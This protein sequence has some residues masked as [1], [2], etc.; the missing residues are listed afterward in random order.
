MKARMLSALVLVLLATSL[1]GSLSI[2][3]T[4]PL[5][6]FDCTGDLFVLDDG[7]ECIL[8]ITPG[9]V[10]AIEV[11]EAQILAAT[12]ETEVDFIDNGIAFDA[13]GAM[14]FTENASNAILKRVPGG[15]VTVLTTEADIAAATGAQESDEGEQDGVD[16]EGIAFSDDGFLYVSDDWSDFVLQVDPTTGAVTAYVT[17]A[18]L[19]ALGVIANADLESSIVGAEGGIVYTASDGDPDAIFKI[20][21]GGTPSVLASGAPFA[22]LDVFMTR[23]PNG[24]LIIADDD[25]DTIRRVTPAGVVST[26]LSEA[27]LEDATCVGQEVNLQGGIAFDDAGSFYVAEEDTD[28]IYEFDAALQC[29][30]FVS[31]AAIQAVTGKDPDFEAGI[32]F[33]PRQCPPPVPIGGYVVPVDKLGLLA[34]WLGLAALASLAA[35]TVALVRR[36]RG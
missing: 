14:Y 7:C 33:A 35:L 11:T 4:P 13:V 22:D 28:D 12:G 10:V 20:D 3:A 16:P 5:L 17:E 25:A 26:F 30:Q 2:A 21:A 29:S 8:R 27:Q 1:T 24:D 32:A 15:A 36:R 23:A 34:P 31:E 19:E 9:G 6:P 18:A